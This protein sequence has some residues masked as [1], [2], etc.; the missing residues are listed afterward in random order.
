MLFVLPDEMPL[1]EWAETNN[2]N[3]RTAQGWAKSGK[4]RAK[5]K[6][7]PK[8]LWI[9]RL[10]ETYVVSRGQKSPNDAM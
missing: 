2:V 3:Y 7:W 5:K 6:K 4:I 8:R 9:T 10:V 1:R